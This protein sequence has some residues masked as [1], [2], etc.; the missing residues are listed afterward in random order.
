MEHG[1]NPAEVLHVG[2]SLI[3]D[4]SGA[5]QAGIKVAWINRNHKPLPSNCSPDYIVKSLEELLPILA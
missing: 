3:S 1:L 5:Q 4:V 2:D